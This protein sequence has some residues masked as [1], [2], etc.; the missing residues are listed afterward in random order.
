MPAGDRQRTWFPEMVEAL[1]AEWRAEMSW[2]E[3][4]ALRDRL[5]N[6]LQ[7]IRQARHITLAR[8][9]TPCPCCGGTMVQGSASVSVRATI[10]ALGRFAIAPEAEVK[11]LE[12]RWNK[13]RAATGCDLYGNKP[14][15]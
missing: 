6:M 8:T 7:H 10:L 11:L 15:S 5:D 12:K 14:T 9:S 3:L 2:D 4:I 1:R 13:Y